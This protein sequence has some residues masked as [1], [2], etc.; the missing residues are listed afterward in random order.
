VLASDAERETTVEIL[1]QAIAEGRVNAEEGSQR[2]GAALAAR[3]RH[4]LAA[5]ARDLPS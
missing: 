3:Y 2:I 4:D 5:L 1:S